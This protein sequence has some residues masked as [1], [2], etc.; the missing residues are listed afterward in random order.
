MSTAVGMS[1][2]GVRRA[3]PTWKAEEAGRTNNYRVMKRRRPDFLQASAAAALAFLSIKVGV[4]MAVCPNM[5]SGHGECGQDNVCECESGW[6]L[7]ADCSLKSCPTG[8]SWAS[9]VTAI[10]RKSYY[11]P[12]QCSHTSGYGELYCFAYNSRLLYVQTL[13]CF[14]PVMFRRVRGNIDQSKDVY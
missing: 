14:P 4:V 2:R 8:A 7:V 13:R 1:R 11:A 3:R 5:C 6:N 9:K 12:S 10:H